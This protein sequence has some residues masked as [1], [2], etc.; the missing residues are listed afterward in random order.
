MV[1]RNILRRRGAAPRDPLRSSGGMHEGGPLRRGIAEFLRLPLLIT[2]AFCTAGVLVSILDSLGDHAPLRSLAETIVPGNGAIQFLSAVATSLATVTA[3]TFSV[4][5]LAIQQTSSSL[6]TVVLDHFLRRTANQLYFGF[7]VGATAF[8]FIVLGLA[9]DDPAPVHGAA[10]TLILMIAALVVLLLLIRGTVDQMRPPSV[11]RSIHELALRAR[12]NELVLLGRTRKQR[13]TPETAPER[14]VRAP[15]SGYVVTIDIDRLARTA[16]AAGPDAEIV[17]EGR[18]GAYLIFDDVV[19][20]LVGADPADSSHDEDILAAFGMDDVRDVDIESRYAV[21]QLENIVWATG[22]SAFQSP[23]TAT[24]AVRALTD[25]LGRWL[26]GGERDRSKKSREN[27]ELPVVYGDDIAQLGLAAL[28]N[29]VIGSAESSQV[30]TC[31][32]LIRSFAHLAPRLHD[33]DKRDF[34]ESLDAALPAVI[35]HAGVPMLRHALQKLDTAMRDAGLDTARVTKVN[36]LLTEATHRL[37]PKP[38]N[39]PAAAHP[40]NIAGEGLT[41]EE[42]SNQELRNAFYSGPWVSAAKK[43]FSD[44]SGAAYSL[45][46]AYL[47]GDLNRQDHLETALK[48]INGGDRIDAYMAKHQHDQNAEELWNYFQDVITWTKKTFPTYRSEMKGLPWGEYYNDFAGQTWDAASLET[49][50]AALMQDDEINRKSGIYHYVLNGDERHLN[51]RTFDHAMQATAYER[52][53]GICPMCG[54][55]FEILEMHANHKLPWS[56]N[57]KTTADNCQMLCHDDTLAKS[58][59]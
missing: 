51:L 43:I 8:T 49:R 16:R 40:T 19:A 41:N 56:K 48:W 42:L 24:A 17:V 23:N 45:G 27:E 9:H 5:L 22:S 26:I 7:F 58:A 28:G 31:T 12:E 34:V 13:A 11:I 25:L 10:L 37:M 57:G 2:L 20:R 32:E 18:L 3:I 44:T 47:A 33:T 50:I 4:L 36:G 14:P 15:D 46:S 59:K 54:N 1:G 30:Q 21:A 39:D 6:T 55:H 52:Q 29:L 53:Q 35:Q 38:S